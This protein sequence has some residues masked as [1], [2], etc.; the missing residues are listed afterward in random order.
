MRSSRI[1]VIVF[2][3]ARSKKLLF[4]SLYLIWSPITDELGN[5]EYVGMHTHMHA[6]IK[7]YPCF[8]GDLGDR[9]GCS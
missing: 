3:T 6:H 2:C 5:N 7:V 9:G 8:V 4:F 1:N